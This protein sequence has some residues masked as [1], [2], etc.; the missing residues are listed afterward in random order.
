VFKKITP[1]L[2]QRLLIIF[3]CS[4]HLKDNTAGPSFLPLSVSM[5]I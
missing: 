5:D 3:F 4:F 1:R 2:G